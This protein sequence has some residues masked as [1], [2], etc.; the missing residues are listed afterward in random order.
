MVGRPSEHVGILD[1]MGRVMW[2]DASLGI[3]SVKWLYKEGSEAQL[4][5][6]LISTVKLFRTG[7]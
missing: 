6:V 3:Q 4:T 2:D 7:S 1:V 5:A